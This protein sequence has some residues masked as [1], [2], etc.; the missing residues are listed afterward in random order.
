MFQSWISN[1]VF[2]LQP[3]RI[4]YAFLSYLSSNFPISLQP[5]HT[6]FEFWTSHSIISSTLIENLYLDVLQTL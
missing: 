2:S 4:A 1:K 5:F 3:F 6:L